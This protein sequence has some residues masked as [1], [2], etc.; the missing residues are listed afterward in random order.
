MLLVS[1]F[2]KYT[3]SVSVQG[4]RWYQLLTSCQHKRCVYV[5]VCMVDQGNDVKG[6][7]Y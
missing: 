5:S 2:Y 3:C 6:P 7:K 1:V 4:F